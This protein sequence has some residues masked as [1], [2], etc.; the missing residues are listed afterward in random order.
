MRAHPLLPATS[1]LCAF[2]DDWI[3]RVYYSVHVCQPSHRP[4][5]ALNDE[6]NEGMLAHVHAHI[7]CLNI[8][9]PLVMEV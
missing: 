5:L 9:A 3:I 8:Q 2:G 7:W 4:A 6:V 1:Q